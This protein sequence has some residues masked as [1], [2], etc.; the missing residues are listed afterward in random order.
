MG[1]HQH[2]FLASVF[3]CMESYWRWKY[4]CFLKVCHGF[5]GNYFCIVSDMTWQDTRKLLVHHLQWNVKIN[6]FSRAIQAHENFN[7]A[8]RVKGTF[9]QLYVCSGYNLKTFLSEESR[10][11]GSMQFYL[12]TRSFYSRNASMTIFRR[13]EKLS[14]PGLG[15]AHLLSAHMQWWASLVTA[16]LFWII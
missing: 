3:S 11:K 16:K 1:C 9:P 2:V 13:D 5:M 8:K 14:I 4:T 10:E 6:T 15:F 7:A 12:T